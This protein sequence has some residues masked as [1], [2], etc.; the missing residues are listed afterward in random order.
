MM[1]NGVSSFIQA[2]DW[3]CQSANSGGASVYISSGCV[4]M[5]WCGYRRYAV[6][7]IRRIEGR[8]FIRHGHEILT[9]SFS[10][11]LG[12]YELKVNS[13][14]PPNFPIR[15]INTFMSFIYREHKQIQTMQILLYIVYTGHRPLARH[16]QFQLLC[17]INV[18]NFR[19]F[20]KI[21]R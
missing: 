18:S 9:N 11:T 16:P 2:L 8:E 12:K 7:A 21:F 17:F 20:L 15:S 10:Y 4:Y 5:M 6:C 3:H 1:T 19:L 13:L 14:F